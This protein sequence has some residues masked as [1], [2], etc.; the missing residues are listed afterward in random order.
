MGGGPHRRRYFSD[1]LGQ[2]GVGLGEVRQ[3]RGVP[4]GRRGFGVFQGKQLVDKARPVRATLGYVLE[5]IDVFGMGA[6]HN[7]REDLAGFTQAQAREAAA[8]YR[9]RIEVNGIGDAVVP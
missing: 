6:H 5:G 1:G 4:V 8:K 3:A 2:N 9:P 7:S